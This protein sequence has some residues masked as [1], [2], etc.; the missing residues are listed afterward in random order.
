MSLLD[1]FRTSPLK[2]GDPAAR[3]AAVRQLGPEDQA[4]LAEIAR[5][6]PEA[7]VRRA[8]A[9]RLADTSVLVELS[10]ADADEAVRETA[11]GVLLRRARSEADPAA[12][13]GALAGLTQSRHLAEVARESPVAEVRA[14]AVRRLDSP[15]ALAAVARTATHADAR[16]LAVERLQDGALLAELATKCEYKD[17]ALAAVERITD[18]AALEA[19]AARARSRAAV[20]RAQA[21]L[22]AMPVPEAAG[23]PEAAPAVPEAAAPPAGEALDDAPTREAAM[24]EPPARKAEDHSPDLSARVL[25]C[26]TVESLEGED[27]FAALKEAEEAWARLDPADDA[28]AEALARRFR[29]GVLGA[30]RRHDA[31]FAA[32]DRRARMDALCTELEEVAD[33]PD[34]RVASERWSVLRKDWAGLQ[35]MDQVDEETVARYARAVARLEA[36]QAEA[37]DVREQEAAQSL[38]RL[39]A[40]CA[41]LEALAAEPE[42]RLADAQRALRE[43]RE[44]L[45]EP[46]RLPTRRERD[47]LVARLKAARAALYPRAQELRQADE[48][49]RWANLAVQEEL[50]RR[51]EELA[52]VEDLRRVAR[53]LRELEERWKQ[54]SQ[55][56]REQAE[57]TWKRFKAARAAVRA[58]CKTFFA[59][60]AAQR[61][62]NLKRK[63]AL[64]AE[65]ESLAESTDWVKTAERLQALQAEWQAAGSVP[66]QQAGPLWERFRAACGRFFER[67]KADR[68]RRAAERRGNLEKKEALVAQAEALV[69]STDWDKAQ[70]EIKKL[71][72]HWKAVGSV[73]K[74]RSEAVWRRFR[75]ACDQVFDRYRKR[76]EIESAGRLDAREAVC[77]SLEAL[78]PAAEGA[79][80]PDDLGA[81]I[82]AAQAAMKDGGRIGGERAEALDKRLQEAVQRLVASWPD[83]FR[84]TDLDPAANRKKLEKLCETVE[85]LV[86]ERPAKDAAAS[87][88]ELLARQL[89]EA[90]ASNTMRGRVDEGARRREV[91]EKV[92]A[93]QAAFDR[94]G[95]VPG[96]E[97]R[98]LRQRFENACRL[99]LKA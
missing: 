57:A 29:E 15:R 9:G 89:R 3:A 82:R 56:P 49:K 81:R 66:R 37:R 77:S 55:A 99:L 14:E 85:A 2:S 31:W 30:R 27:A 11:A 38:A 70:A 52:A 5:G 84:G 86:S 92:A 33:H 61:T 19:V 46:P 58:R 10:R 71:Q 45:R 28:E 7:I 53:E 65:A 47:L 95:Q 20:R 6:D 43:S 26:Q 16:L 25:L 18:R 93:A 32:R 41:R 91:K 54:A 17:A 62:E 80:P 42:P 13:R 34:L 4:Q 60:E 44:A 1:R 21:L 51:L 8:A 48:W 59:A 22:E 75:Q 94:L 98:A 78:L 72:A 74:D 97:G 63:E 67:R 73:R 36:R 83:A 90:L 69:A 64:L 24:D 23:A 68:A 96:E 87:P 76:D 40:L 39:Q 88:A 50:C 12:G 79:P 35:S